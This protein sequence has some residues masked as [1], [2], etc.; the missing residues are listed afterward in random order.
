MSSTDKLTQAEAKTRALQISDVEYKLHLDLG[1]DATYDGDCTISFVFTPLSSSSVDDSVFLDFSGHTVSTLTLNKEELKPADCFRARRVYLKKAWLK[2]FNTLRIVFQNKYD[3]DG[4]GLHRFKDPL[5]EQVYLYSNFEPFD[6]HRMFP[7][8][9]QPNLKAPLSLT[10]RAPKEWLVVANSAHVKEGIVDDGKDANYSLHT[11]ATTKKLSTY[12]YACIA[13]P[14]QQVTDMYDERVPL[15]LLCR[16]SLFQY[17][18]YKE[19]FELTKSGLQYYEKFFNYQYPF[20]KYDQVFCPEYNLGA[21]ENPGCITFNEFYLYKFTPS[22]R[23][24]AR[25]ADTFLHEMAHMWFGDLTT[26]DWWDGLWLNES[27]ATYMAACCLF[28]ATEFKQLSWE[29]FHSSEKIGA[30][31]S[32]QLITTHPVQADIPDTEASVSN[33]DNITYGKGASLL[34]QLVFHVG[35]DGFRIGMEHYF[36]TFEWKN[37]NISDFLGALAYGA[38]QA[39]KFSSSSSS[40][41]TSSASTASSSTLK[42]VAVDQTAKSSLPSDSSSSSTTV[43]ATS[44]LLDA[45][46]WS[47]THLEKAGLNIWKPKITIEKGKITAFEIHQSGAPKSHE[48]FRSQYTQIALFDLVDATPV[49]KTKEEKEIKTEKVVEKVLRLRMKKTVLVEAKA[50]TELLDF[51]DMAAPDFVYVNYE[52]MAYAIIEFD[53]TTANFI[54]KNHSAFTDSL[55]RLQLWMDLYHLVR[56]ANLRGTDFLDLVAQQL[57]KESY[58]PTVQTIIMTASTV[59]SMFIPE[60]LRKQPAE[61]LY[62]LLYKMATE[63]KSTDEHLVYTNG[64]LNFVDE[65]PQV[66]YLIKFLA[67]SFTQTT[68]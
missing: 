4:S 52:D 62:Q 37:T 27:F 7:C 24:R 6:C 10:V 40:A 23:H 59:H 61:R 58:L 8:F 45:V 53:S 66:E 31:E 57:P 38:Q 28:E 43:R 5:D 17:M 54:L 3:T 48:H 34:K 44:H 50:V 11:F 14:Y 39:S 55:L 21:M 60:H 16:K 13:G 12:L 35:A 68:R 67:P 1:K 46:S 22:F 41:S 56:S 32:D 18:P 19:L 42:T 20:D 65:K 2:S 36:K 15:G 63:S 9:D 29:M 47:E 30:Y 64:L 26:C 51:N 49:T 25:R 33:F